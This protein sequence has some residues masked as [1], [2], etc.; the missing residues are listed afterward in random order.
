VKSAKITR[1][2][3]SQIEITITRESAAFK[4]LFEREKEGFVLKN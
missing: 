3:A 4:W 1:I 2:G